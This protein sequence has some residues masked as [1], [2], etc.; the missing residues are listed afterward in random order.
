MFRFHQPSATAEATDG[1]TTLEAALARTTHLGVGAHPDDIEFMGWHPILECLEDR[2]SWLTGVIVSDGR[3]SPRSGLYA[4]LADDDMVGLRVKE[5]HHAAVIG[6]YSAMVHLLYPETG[7]VMGA[8]ASLQPVVDD[9]KQVIQATRPRVIFTHNLTD[10][11]PH[12]TVVA[13]SLIRA[14]RELGA[15]FFPEQFY[16]GEVWRGLDWLPLQHKL[17]FDVSQHQN[18]T[19]SLMGVYDS[20]ITGGKRYDLATA[21]RKRANATYHDPLS[22]DTASVLEYAMDLLPML[23]EPELDPA[24][25]AARLIETFRAEVD[26]RLKLLWSC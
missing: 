20:Q 19:A 6:R 9:L 26:E 1:T 25:Y 2:A 10:K 17:T 11:H 23:K 15:E 22:T 21:G 5:Q 16:G 7:E 18:L 8:K 4:D 3:S 14:L 24:G 12:H 13:V